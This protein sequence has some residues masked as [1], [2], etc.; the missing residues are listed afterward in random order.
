M[1]A[2]GSA[3]PQTSE[4][5]AVVSIP[6]RLHSARAQSPSAAAWT[7]PF[8]IADAVLYPFRKL[9][10]LRHV[11][12]HLGQGRE[13]ESKDGITILRRSREDRSRDSTWWFHA[14]PSTVTTPM[15][16]SSPFVDSKLIKTKCSLHHSPEALQRARDRLVSCCWALHLASVQ[17]LYIPSISHFPLLTHQSLST[18][19][20]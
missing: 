4:E 5:G 1:K 8:P 16:I 13:A 2:W 12:H 7:E 14:L 19:H 18:F 9:T 20:S 10:H 11:S 6:D 3:T 15:V 17:I